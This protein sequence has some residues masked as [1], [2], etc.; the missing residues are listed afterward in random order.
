M[1][2]TNTEGP[3]ERIARVLDTEAFDPAA[4]IRPW[5]GQTPDEARAAAQRVALQQADAILAVLPLANETLPLATLRSLADGWDAHTERPAGDYREARAY[6]E[7]V[8]DGY[9]R[10]ADALRARIDQPTPRWVPHIVAQALREAADAVAFE[11][12]NEVSGHTST[13][14]VRHWLRARA[15]RLDEPAGGK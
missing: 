10:A 1:S 14:S 11:L 4:L 7:G 6:A 12:G 9:G 13:Y 2:E 15:D 5:F 3:R 8:E